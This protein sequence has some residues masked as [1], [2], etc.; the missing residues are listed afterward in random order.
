MV[1][2]LIQYLRRRE[3]FKLSVRTEVEVFRRRHG[4][5]AHQFALEKADRPEITTHYRE[6]LVEAA[7]QLRKQVRETKPAGESGS[8]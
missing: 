5:L 3:R 2:N 7:K 8:A 4:D 6:I 1:P